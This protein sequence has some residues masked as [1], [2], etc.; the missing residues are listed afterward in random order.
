[1]EEEQGEREGAFLLGHESRKAEGKL[2]WP[3]KKSAAP[4][5]GR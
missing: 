1:V 2:G 3:W 5:T 4:V